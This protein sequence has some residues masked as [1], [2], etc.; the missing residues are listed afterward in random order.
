VSESLL[1]PAMRTAVG[2]PSEP[3]TVDIERGAIVRFAEAIGDDNPRFRGE[4]PIAPPTFLRSAGRAI[5][6]FPDGNRVP[7][8]LDGGSEWT[9]GPPIVAGDRIVFTTRLESLTERSGRMGPML[10]AIYLTEYVN[11]AGELAA[12]Q[13]NTIIRMPEAR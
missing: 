8:V 3:R 9:Y 12:T 5:P 11:Q 1:T 6:D 10:I 7:R 4:R 13:R 2:V